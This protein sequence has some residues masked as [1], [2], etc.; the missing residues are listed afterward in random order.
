[1]KK[2]FDGYLPVVIDVET[3][4][5][6][7]TKNGLLELAVVIVAYNDLGELQPIKSDHWH[8]KPHKGAII[9]P[10][11]LAINGIDPEHPF[12]FAIDESQA[13]E[14]LCEFVT[15]QVKHY[16]CRRAVLVGHNAHFDL[17]FIITAIKRCHIKNNPFHAF[18]CFDTATLGGLV[19][20]KTVLAKILRTANITFDKELA[21]S[22]AYDTEKTA[23]LFCKIINKQNKD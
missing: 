14:E 7:F 2:R 20:G 5:V 9:N 17:N 11:A 12:R 18:T 8:I 19:Y 23:E 1:M 22:A 15:T 21:H 10:E 16:E 13:L 6:D 4:G 3:T